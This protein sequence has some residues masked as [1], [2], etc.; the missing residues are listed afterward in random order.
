MDTSYATKF[1]VE[2]DVAFE[3]MDGWPER[4]SRLKKLG[5]VVKGCSCD[6]GAKEQYVLHSL[7]HFG[8][9][10]RDNSHAWTC[11]TIR[12][13]FVTWLHQMEEQR[14]VSNFL[15]GTGSN[16]A[17]LV[18]RV[19]QNEP[20]QAEELLLLAAQNAWRVAIVGKERVIFS[21]LADGTDEDIYQQDAVFTPE[22][23]GKL[24]NCAR[25]KQN[26]DSTDTL[27][28]YNM[29]EK[30]PGGTVI[31]I[32]GTPRKRKKD[33]EKKIEDPEKSAAPEEGHQGTEEDPI[34]LPESP[35]RK[36]PKTDDGAIPGP[37]GSHGGPE[38][39]HEEHRDDF[40][41]DV[42]ETPTKTDALKGKIRSQ[43]SIIASLKAEKETVPGQLEAAREAERQKH[44]S[45][46]VKLVSER[47]NAVR[48][49]EKYQGRLRELRGFLKEIKSGAAK[50]HYA[51]VEWLRAT[52]EEEPTESDKEEAE[53][54]AELTEDTTED[55]QEQ[56]PRGGKVTPTKRTPKGEGA[57]ID[58]G[59]DLPCPLKNCKNIYVNNDDGRAKRNTH[60]IEDHNSK[61]VGCTLCSA[62]FKNTQNQKLHI[63]RF[64]SKIMKFKCEI[65]SKKSATKSDANDHH[66]VHFKNFRCLVCTRKAGENYPRKGCRRAL[67][68]HLKT[69]HKWTTEDA[70]NEAETRPHLTIDDRPH[71][72]EEMDSDRDEY[73]KFRC[74]Y[75]EMVMIDTEEELERHI[76]EE[77][78]DKLA[79]ES[80]HRAEL[81][82]EVGSREKSK[83]GGKGSKQKVKKTVLKCK[84]CGISFQDST[85][86]RRHENDCDK[87][88]KHK[89]NI[90]DGWFETL[91]EQLKHIGETHKQEVTPKSPERTPER[92][93]S[94][95]K[96][97]PST[98]K[99][100][101]KS[102]RLGAYAC[103]NCEEKFTTLNAATHHAN[104]THGGM[105]QEGVGI[106]CAS[107]DVIT[108]TVD[109]HT[110]HRNIHD[111]QD[112]GNTE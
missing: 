12:K 56:P 31:K 69:V 100:Q 78:Q 53:A 103:W 101:R 59:E 110:V 11:A 44:T 8:C 34:P 79:E 75:C 96:T 55:E 26:V 111:I 42:L 107:C 19:E 94:P 108:A 9:R 18:S 85:E 15:E 63:D 29:G 46:I 98:P 27:T 40:T 13:V 57:G 38:D 52:R 2:F 106:R 61:V 45:L 88:G 43:R 5:L 24:W 10:D 84:F 70:D 90:C 91:D 81:L 4:N 97:P 35:Q 80:K 7:Q 66:G 41:E 28:W 76:K 60:L 74:K 105:L 30:G 58:E 23:D 89:C 86:R 112:Q 32:E 83:R 36:K 22:K 6:A 77:H 48:R 102:P 82:R 93:K 67:A 71:E 14:L 50:Q 49:A 65:C 16:F 95:V 62:H 47:D 54:L 39:S 68:R 37:S 20:L 3:G 33:S 1:P 17:S 92:P 51:S 109:D 64:H 104:E 72:P 21:S 73:D 87:Q 99:G 25:V